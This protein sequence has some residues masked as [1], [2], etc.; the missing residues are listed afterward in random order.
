VNKAFADKFFPGEPVI[1]KRIRPGAT[2]AAGQTTNEIVG[3]VGNAQQ[4]LLRL[5]PEPIY[6][7]A[8]KQLSWSVLSVAV[9]T[10]IP[11]TAAESAVRDV[12]A[13]IDREEPIF[14][15]KTLDDLQS[16]AI[17][18]PRFQMLLLSSFAGVALI[19]IVV[20][21]YGLMAYSVMKRTREIGVRIALGASRSAVLRMV[22]AETLVLV[23]AGLVIGFVASIAGATLLEGLLYGVGPRDPLLLA[24][25][26]S[27]IMATGL[28][29]AYLPAH[30]A[31]TIDPMQALRAE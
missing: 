9:R 15:V 24:I 4:S 13:S 14:E 20:G 1:G 27:V 12:V 23:A 3:V 17:A 6:Y 7:F 18:Q 5:E 30:R 28:L 31:A 22:L 25:A 29:A 10:S 16:T 19:L 8:Y 26:C 11:P 2:G 21:L